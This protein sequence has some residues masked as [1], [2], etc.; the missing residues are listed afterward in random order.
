MLSKAPAGGLE[1]VPGGKL[2]D[3]SHTVSKWRGPGAVLEKGSQARAT[4][5]L[6]QT[7]KLLWGHCYYRAFLLMA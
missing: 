4:S 3:H 5:P 1:A 7:G 2:F 6:L